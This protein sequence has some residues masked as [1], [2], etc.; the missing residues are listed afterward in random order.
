MAGSGTLLINAIA[1]AAIGGTSL[2]GGV[3]LITVVFDSLAQRAAAA[4]GRA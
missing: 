3:L 1:A 4:R 2:S